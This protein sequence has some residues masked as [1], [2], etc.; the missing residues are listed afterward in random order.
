[1]AH[2]RA[3]TWTKSDGTTRKGFELTYADLHGKRFTKSFK[4]KRDA[5]AERIRVENEI[6]DRSHVTSRAS[7]SVMDGMRAWIIYMEELEKN[8]KRERST[9]AKYRSHVE[10]HIAKTDLAPIIMS[11]ITKPD[12]QLF[13][14]YLETRLSTIMAQKVFLTLKIGMKYCRKRG[15]LRMMPTEDFSIEN[16]DRES[17]GKIEIPS[18]EDIKALLK[19]ADE[20]ITGIDGAVVRVLCHCGL[21]PSE[22]RGLRRDGIFSDAAPANLKIMQRADI[23]NKIGKPK[24]RAG[25]RTIPLGPETLRSIKKAMLSRKAGE[26]NLVFPDAEGYVMKYDHF[27]HQWWPKL[28]LRAKLAKTKTVI[29]KSD[30]GREVQKI[31]SKFHPYA[32]RHVA[33]SRWIEMG[34]MPKRIQELMGH[35]SLKMTMDIYGHL[36]VNPAADKEIA[37]VTEQA[38]A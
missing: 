22:M 5:D 32:L 36:W 38:F 31:V 21:R 3:R 16:R 13:V 9:V 7:R 12:M 20:D 34:I 10:Y 23:Y 17:S 1:M 24:S 8:G 29:Y 30:P 18:K 4:T 33:A 6:E 14:E 28:M 11:E 2:I 25:Y 26:R 37:A 27:V 35:S 15:W 19:V